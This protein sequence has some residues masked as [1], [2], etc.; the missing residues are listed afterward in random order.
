MYIYY[1]QIYDNFNNLI[2]EKNSEFIHV[3]DYLDLKLI[4]TTSKNIYT[5]IPPK[6]KTQ[7]N[8]NIINYFLISI[9]K[10]SFFLTKNLYINN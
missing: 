2:L 1:C 6:L 7:T 4:V 10:N 3:N 5:G 8:A 9:G